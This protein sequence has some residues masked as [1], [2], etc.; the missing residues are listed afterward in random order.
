MGHVRKGFYTLHAASSTLQTAC[1]YLLFPFSFVEKGH[2]VAGERSRSW[3]RCCSGCSAASPRPRC[4]TCAAA[5]RRAR[6]ATSSLTWTSSRCLG[7][8]G[9]R[10]QVSGGVMGVMRR[11][12]GVAMPVVSTSAP[13]F[14]FLLAQLAPGFGWETVVAPYSRLVLGALVI[15]NQTKYLG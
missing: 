15:H 7:C 10:H 11:T 9:R 2:R 1:K 13:C 5:R 3:R 14:A 12:D 4:S 6:R 8:A